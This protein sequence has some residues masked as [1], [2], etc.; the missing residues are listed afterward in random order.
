[1]LKLAL[2][3]VPFAL[4]CLGGC[5]FGSEDTASPNAA[6]GSAF[7]PGCSEKSPRI[8]ALDMHPSA[9]LAATGEYVLTGTLRASCSAVSIDARSE[10]SSTSDFRW[11]ATPGADGAVPI[12]MRF[13]ASKKGS[14][15]AYDF[16]V[17]D[18]SNAASSSLRQTF[19]L[20]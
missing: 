9:T 20:E 16:T 18:A 4:A 17:R 7:S 8:L 11:A 15:L 13:A 3:S 6:S 12:T 1:M 5:V 2:L 14:S 10:Y 19:S